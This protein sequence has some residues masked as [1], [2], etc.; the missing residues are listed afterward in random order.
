MNAQNKSSSTVVD[1]KNEINLSSSLLRNDLQASL[2]RNHID[3]S[4]LSTFQRI[5]LTTDGTV[6]DILEAYL[7]EQIRVVKLSEQLVSL[8]HE[9]PSMDLKEGT[10]VIVRKILLQGKISRKNVVYA[11]SIV[12]PEKLEEKFRKALLETKVPIGKIWFE[13]RVETFKEILDSKKELA[14]DLADYFNIDPSDEMLSRTYRVVTNRKS[15]MMITEKFPESY[16][17]KSL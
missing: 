14:G 16:F 6:T 2:T 4:V 12:V 7:F 17:L 9:I 15:V 11:E 13:Q 1:A 8:A 10:E 3:P 5:L